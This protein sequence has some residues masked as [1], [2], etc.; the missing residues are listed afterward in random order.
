VIPNP[1][2]RWFAIYYRSIA[3][4]FDGMVSAQQVVMGPDQLKTGRNCLSKA[5]IAGLRLASSLMLLSCLA[6]SA[7]TASSIFL[8]RPLTNNPAPFTWS[9]VSRVGEM[10][11]VAEDQ[12]GPRDESWTLLGVELGAKAHAEVWYPGNT[13]QMIIQLTPMCATNM[14]EACYEAAHETVHLLEPSL[15]STVI[16]EG[17]ATV[18]A[19]DYV[20]RTWGRGDSTPPGAYRRASG[21]VRNLLSMDPYI[22]KKIRARQPMFSAMTVSDI[23][24]ACPQLSAAQAEQLVEPFQ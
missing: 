9:I 23:T 8:A 17:A 19:E 5:I 3:K 14:I 21:L 18:F 13:R 16:E 10:L 2:L 15:K 4:F 1:R 11:A 7:Q 20:M 22:I 24:N 12:Y 6:A